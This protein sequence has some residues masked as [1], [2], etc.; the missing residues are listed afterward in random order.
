MRAALACQKRGTGFDAAAVLRDVRHF[1]SVRQVNQ[2]EVALRFTLG[3]LSG[4]LDPGLQLV[5]PGLQKMV[6]IDLE[7]EV[8]ERR[9]RSAR[10]KAGVP[11]SDAISQVGMLQQYH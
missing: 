9:R 10:K 7:A 3:K 6:R 5:I 2:W 4:R 1:Q 8:L 11:I